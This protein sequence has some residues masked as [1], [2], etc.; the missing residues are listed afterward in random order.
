MTRP[1]TTTIQPS[2]RH[3]TAPCARLGRCASAVGVQPGS[4]G[5]APSA[6]NL[7]L[8]QY[9]VSESLFGTLSMNTVHKFFSKKIKHNNNNKIK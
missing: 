1:G 5:C 9:T 6:P 7:V 2:A 4:F 8:T 3:D